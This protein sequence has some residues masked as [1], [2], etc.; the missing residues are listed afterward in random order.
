MLQDNDQP[1]IAAS[2][3]DFKDNLFLMYDWAAVNIVK[4]EKSVTGNDNV[5]GSMSQ[6][7]LD[8]LKD[9]VYEELAETFL[10]EVFEYEA[11]LKRE[12]WEKIVAKKMS[13]VFSPKQIREKLGIN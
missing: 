6:N 13:Y 5:A 9:E 2:D 3:K 10:D 1:S 7:V 4:Y 8:R 11:V 12:Q